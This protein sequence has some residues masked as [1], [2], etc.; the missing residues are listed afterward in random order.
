[1]L[2]V[3]IGFDDRQAVSYHVLCASIMKHASKPV[4]ITPLILPSLP[5]KRRGLTPFTFSRF[6]CPYL[7]D[8]KGTSLFLDADILARADLAT[9]PNIEETYHNVAL[10]K[11]KLKFEWSSVML[12]NN[13]FCRNLTPEYIDDLSHNPMKMEWAI[14]IAELPPEWNHLVGY[15]EPNPNAKLVHFTQGVPVWPE[16]MNSEHAMEWRSTM[17]EL[18][19]A[20]PWAEIMGNSVHAKPV[21]ERLQT[22]EAA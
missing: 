2:R 1:V 14:D 10:V 11:N 3:F 13:A 19:Q 8:F 18:I 17:L 15:D 20:K 9:L 12:F 5:I 16:T 21:L 7:C 6:L 4:S 22:G